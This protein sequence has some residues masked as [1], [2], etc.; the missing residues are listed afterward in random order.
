MKYQILIDIREGFTLSD[1]EYNTLD[2][3]VKEAIRQSYGSFKFKI[4]QVINWKAKESEK[5]K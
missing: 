3:A 2:E 4:V 5:N 1:E